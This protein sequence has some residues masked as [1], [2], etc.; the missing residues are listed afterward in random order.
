M[1]DGAC[2]ETEAELRHVIERLLA[3]AGRRA[4]EAE[5]VCDAR[6]PDGSRVNVVLPPLA[7]DG[8]SLTI[9]RFRPRGLH[10]DELVRIGSWTPP[11]Q[12]PAARGDRRAR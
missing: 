11:L 4:D 10:P 9:R 5:P 7:V 1:H 3:P 8:P 12:R 2:F 6:L